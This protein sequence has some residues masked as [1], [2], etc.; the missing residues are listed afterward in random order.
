MNGWCLE[1]MS[2]DESTWGGRFDNFG[3]VPE[4]GEHATTALLIDGERVDCCV[5]CATAINSNG[6]QY[7]RFGEVRK[8]SR[9]VTVTL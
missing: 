1:N 5:A 2:A 8:A 9:I 7:D 6:G 3:E 4:C